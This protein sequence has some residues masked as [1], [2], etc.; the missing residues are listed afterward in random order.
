M[1]LR[2]KIAVIIYEGGGTSSELADKVLALLREGPW[3]DEAKERMRAAYQRWDPISTT[4]TAG[5]VPSDSQMDSLMD[6]L[7]R[8]ALGEGTE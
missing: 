7:L 4:R 5:A 1:S 3:F 8:A 2:N 6:L